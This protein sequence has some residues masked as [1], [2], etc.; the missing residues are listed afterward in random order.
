V[1]AV[2][3]AYNEDPTV[4][5]VVRVLADSGVFEDVVVVDDG[6]TDQTVANAE[7]AGALVISTPRNLGKGGAML[8]AYEALR[9]IGGEDDRVAFFDADLI[10]LEPRHLQRLDAASRL[11]YDQVAGLQDKGEV[12]NVLQLVYS[13]LIT[14][15]R[16]LRRWVL[17]ALPETCWQGYSIETAINDVVERAGGKTMLVL[18]DG[19]SFRKK[20]D[21]VSMLEA[22]RGYWRMTRQIAD[23]RRALRQSSGMTCKV[24]A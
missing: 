19:V 18:L 11:G 8:F 10:D 5:G 22:L 6:S 3:P 16:I 12:S 15:Q 4:A 13:P 17:D 23:T 24:L 1:Y 7:S 9:E 14:G 2:V 20:F 21:K